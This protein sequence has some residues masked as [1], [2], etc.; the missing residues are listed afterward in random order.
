M[1]LLISLFP[2]PPP[3][4]FLP[5][6]CSGHFFPLPCPSPCLL[7]SSPASTTNVQNDELLHKDCKFLILEKDNTPAKKEMELLIMT[8][9]SGKVFTAS[10]ATIAASTREPTPCRFQERGR[11]YRRQ[12]VL[13]RWIETF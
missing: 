7:L 10:P 4:A 3:P 1:Q 6:S 2:S 8:K 9:D 5:F 11:W 13:A 12:N